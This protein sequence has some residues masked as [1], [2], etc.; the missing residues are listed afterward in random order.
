MRRG[1]GGPPKITEPSASTATIFTPW[2]C[3]FRRRESPAIVP[4]ELT[5]TNTKSRAVNA[6]QISRPV[7]WKWAIIPS[8]FLYWLGQ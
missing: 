7:V 2:K 6:S 3:S 8:G 1:R 5:A 4:A